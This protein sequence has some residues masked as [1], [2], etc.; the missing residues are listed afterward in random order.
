MWIII[1]KHV[2]IALLTICLCVNIGSKTHDNS[3]TGSRNI[4]VRKANSKI[5]INL[6]KRLQQGGMIINEN[7][8]FFS[9]KRCKKNKTN[10]YDIDEDGQKS[11][12]Y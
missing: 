8:T 2:F 9:Y 10:I 6:Y 1:F 3:R 11:R 7:D 12:D 5:W 4:I